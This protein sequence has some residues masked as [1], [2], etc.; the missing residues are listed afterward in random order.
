MIKDLTNDI[1]R[2]SACQTL[3]RALVEHQCHV[4]LYITEKMVAKSELKAKDP[5]EG[6]VLWKEYR[7][8]VQNRCRG[9]NGGCR[10]SAPLIKPK[11]PRQI[12]GRPD[13]LK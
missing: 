10:G 12:S 2:P 11:L 6:A 8:K 7:G 13:T 5:T 3:C 1:A 4:G 9:G